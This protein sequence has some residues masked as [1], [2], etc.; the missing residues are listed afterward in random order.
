[1]KSHIKDILLT[2]MF[3]LLKLNPIGCVTFPK[4]PPKIVKIFQKSE[5]LSKI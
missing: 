3:A 5:N 2:N 1:M 4:N